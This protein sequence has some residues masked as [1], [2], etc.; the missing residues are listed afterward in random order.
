VTARRLHQLVVAAVVA[1][2]LV[3]SAA[4]AAQAT[5]LR[6]T[7]PRVRFSVSGDEPRNDNLWI[8][9]TAINKSAVCGVEGCL[10]LFV[11]FQ[12][13]AAER[14]AHVHPLGFGLT[15]ALA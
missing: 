1:S 13:N 2:G 6:A 9:G 14:T 10:L 12:Y 11:M 5:D 7:D 4:G 8:S 15:R 3:A